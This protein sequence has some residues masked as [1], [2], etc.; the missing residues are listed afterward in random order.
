MRSPEETGLFKEM[1]DGRN[2]A[3]NS[4]PGTPLNVRKQEG[5][6]RLLGSCEKTEEPAQRRFYWPKMN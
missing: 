1:A 4:K 3:T 2:E 6:Q 5:A